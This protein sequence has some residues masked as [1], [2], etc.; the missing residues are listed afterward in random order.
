MDYPTFI[1]C[2]LQ[3]DFINIPQGKMEKDS[4]PNVDLAII[5]VRKSGEPGMVAQAY[6]P[7]TW[8]AEAGGS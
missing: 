1:L 6:Y 3:S 7:S 2:L 4:Q 5:F 8:E